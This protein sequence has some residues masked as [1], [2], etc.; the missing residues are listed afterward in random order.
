[1]RSFLFTALFLL[2][3]SSTFANTTGKWTGWVYWSFQG[4]GTKCFSDLTLKETESVLHR[5]GGFFDCDLVTMEVN[6]QI[7]DKVG[8]KLFLGE[9]E[10]GTFQDGTYQWREKYSSDVMIENTITVKGSN[11]DYAE[12]WIQSDG[13]DL[14][15]I[16]GRFFKK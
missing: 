7:L 4:S 5:V 1:M 12:K 6:E 11:M 16:E 13:R 3:S 14:Y 8:N 10:V 2:I 15:K 9:E